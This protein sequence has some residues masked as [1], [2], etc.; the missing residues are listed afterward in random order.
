MRKGNL[1]HGFRPSSGFAFPVPLRNIPEN[2]YMNLLYVYSA[3]LTPKLSAKKTALRE[4]GIKDPINLFG[5]HRHDVPW[6]TQ[7]T[8]G[9]MIPLEFVPPNITCAGPILLSGALASQQDSELADWIKRAPT[10]LINLGSHF[11]VS[12][13]LF[14]ED[15]AFN[16]ISAKE[17]NLNCHSMTRNGPH[18]CP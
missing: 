4:K 14:Y 9:A 7:N 13:L 15:I 12:R 10:V 8:E 16:Y 17:A 11:A 6:I 18:Q 1:A 2:I 5:I 3:M